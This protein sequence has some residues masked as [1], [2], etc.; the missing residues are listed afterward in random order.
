MQVAVLRFRDGLSLSL[1]EAEKRYDGVIQQT[2]SGHLTDNFVA[3]NAFLM[4]LECAEMVRTLIL[5]IRQ[6]RFVSRRSQRSAAFTLVELLVVIAIIGILVALL[7]PA[8]QAAREA[9]RRSQC[10][11]NLKQ[12]GLAVANYE[13]THKALPPGCYLGEGSAWSAFILPFLEE[14]A[15]F[16]WLSIGEGD[17]GNFQWASSSPYSD[18]TTLPNE[19]RNIRVIETPM[20]I[21]RCPSNGMP[22]HQ[23][24]WS[25]D[26]WWVMRRSPGSYIGVVSGLQTIQHPVWRMRARKHPPENPNYEGVDGVLAALHHTEDIGT[27]IKLSQ[28][29][30]GT[31]KTALA[32]EA[33]HDWETVDAKGSTQREAEPGN[34]KDHWWGGSDDVDTN[35]FMDLSEFLGSTGV[36]INVQ[37]DPATNQAACSNPNSPDCQALQLSFGSEHSGVVQMVFVDGHVEAV[38]EGIDPNV[39]SNYGTRANQVRYSGG[40]VIE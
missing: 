33:V 15:A 12:I 4:E 14:G 25:N 16:D 9:A 10:Q 30:D 28:V 11:S 32:G 34:R 1:G 24:D 21:Y 36:P 40:G 6:P 8:I 23:T 20:Q 31:S 2:V 7:L 17:A 13:G 26:G 27:K 38:Q 18:A 19:Y 35:P 37:R 5:P 39:W 29:I 3:A 22:L